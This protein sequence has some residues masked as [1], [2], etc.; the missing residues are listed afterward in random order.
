MTNRSNK[1]KIN[2]MDKMTETHEVLG[3]DKRKKKKKILDMGFV[4]LF[5]NF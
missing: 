3:G 5:K 4:K 2:V 1:K